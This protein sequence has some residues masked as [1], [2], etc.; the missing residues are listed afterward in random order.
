MTIRTV[1]VEGWP[2]PKG[3]ANGVAAT[4]ETLWVAGQIGWTP[5]GVFERKDF[6]GQF[7]QA[8]A[9]VLA[10]VEAAGGSADKIVRLTVY[11]TDLDA[12]RSSLKEIGDVWRRRMGK[13]F[14]AMALV[15]VAG[16]VEREALVEI[17]ATAVLG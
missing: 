13:V 14:P 9:N 2:R 5:E 7:D 11:V 3:Y 17:E 8:L 10:V 15:G 6:L 12:Y 16:L 1:S 4:G